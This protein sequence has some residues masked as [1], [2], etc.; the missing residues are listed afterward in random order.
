MIT[1]WRMTVDD[2]ELFGTWNRIPAFRNCLF[3]GMRSLT[4]AASY[5]GRKESSATFQN[6]TG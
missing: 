4:E 6:R 1:E 3:I 2:S 5:I